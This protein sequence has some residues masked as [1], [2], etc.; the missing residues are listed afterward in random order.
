MLEIC[1]TGSPGYWSRHFHEH[2]PS[3]DCTTSR[4]SGHN[5][6]ISPSC[7]CHLP[8]PRRLTITKGSEKQDTLVQRWRLDNSAILFEVHANLV[9]WCKRLQPSPIAVSMMRRGPHVVKFACSSPQLR[10]FFAALSGLR[11][12]GNGL[13]VS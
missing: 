13:D 12:E 6:A 3:A 1:C 2:R 8:R 10:P 7:E 5:V 11:R 9:T 4:M